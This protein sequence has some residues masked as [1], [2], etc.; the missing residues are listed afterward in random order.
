MFKFAIISLRNVSD[1]KLGMDIVVIAIS[2][3]GH[4]PAVLNLC[5]II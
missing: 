3:D 1:A 5:I 4:D 2:C